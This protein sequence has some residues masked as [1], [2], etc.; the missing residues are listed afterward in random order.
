[1]PYTEKTFEDQLNLLRRMVRDPS[2]TRWG[3]DAK[4]AAVNDGMCQAVLDLRCLP[5]NIALTMVADTAEIA[6]PDDVLT[7]ESLIFDYGGTS[8][9]NLPV[10]SV[11][12][13]DI[14]DSSWRKLSA[15]TPE[16]AYIVG[17]RQIVLVPK[18]NAAAAALVLQCFYQEAPDTLTTVDMAVTPFNEVFALNPYWRVPVLCAVALLLN[19]EGREEAENAMKAE[20]VYERAV[21]KARRQITAE[22]SED[23]K[24]MFYPAMEMYR[25]RR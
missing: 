8:P 24:A 6:Y 15:G 23:I 10:K 4:I 7:I 2:D 14:L 5:Q 20:A 22:T 3:S 25:G 12:N 13:L 1:M 16:K 19:E 21:Q 18:P 17:K 9:K 11:R